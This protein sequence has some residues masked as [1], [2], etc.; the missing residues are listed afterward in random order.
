MRKARIGAALVLVAAVA[1]GQEERVALPCGG[2]EAEL[3]GIRATLEQVV[4]LMTAQAR[5]AKLD[6]AFRR[7]ELALQQMVPLQT[8]ASTLRFAKQRGESLIASSES[9]LEM[10]REQRDTGQLEQ[11]YDENSLGM[12]IR[13]HEEMVKRSRRELS[14]TASRLAEI[15]LETTRFQGEIDEWKRFL[16]QELA[17]RGQ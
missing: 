4:R 2:S 13:M 8:E 1:R 11:G 12:E 10:L 17:R 7:I 6:G 15:D 16:D 5:E 9:R 3:A 14:T